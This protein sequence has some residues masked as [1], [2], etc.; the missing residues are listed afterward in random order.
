MTIRRASAESV[1]PAP[2]Q[3]SGRRRSSRRATPASELR[4]RARIASRA[5]RDIGSALTSSPCKRATPSGSVASQWML[6][7]SP[8]A[9]SRLPPP[10][11]IPRAGPSR[12]A[13]RW[14]KAAKIRCASSWP[15]STRTGVPSTS[16]IRRASWRPLRASRSA[17]VATGISLSTRAAAACRR[18]CRATSMARAQT[19]SGMFPPRATSAPRRSISRS[20]RTRRISPVGVASATSRWKE[21]LPRSSTPTRSFSRPRGAA[22]SNSAAP[23]SR[24]FAGGGT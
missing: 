5:S 1:P 18:S 2:M 7:S 6:R 21:V 4:T 14:R 9:S 19:G 24:S 8:S 23:R 16:P 22:S 15:D 20:R 12:T 11:S 10:R 13:S 17:A 3:S